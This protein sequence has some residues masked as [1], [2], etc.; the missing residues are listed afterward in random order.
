MVFAHVK[1]IGK[2]LFFFVLINMSFESLIKKLASKEHFGGRAQSS[3]Y[4]ATDGGML[5]ID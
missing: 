3:C 4:S 5:M 1:I 2:L